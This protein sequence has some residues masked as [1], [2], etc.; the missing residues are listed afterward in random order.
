MYC[1][2]T[3]VRALLAAFSCDVSFSSSSPV[4]IPVAF[5][6][7]SRHRCHLVAELDEEEPLPP[8]T[9]EGIAALVLLDQVH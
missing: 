4:P 8:P 7:A 2:V 9:A 3:P 6:V 1:H 5:G